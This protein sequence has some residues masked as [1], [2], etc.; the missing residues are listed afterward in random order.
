M[1][2]C[3]IAEYFDVSRPTINDWQRRGAPITNKGGDPALVAGWRARRDLAQAGAGNDPAFHDFP[4]LLENLAQR[5]L[6]LKRRIRMANEMPKDAQGEPGLIKA[7]ICA[8]L[9]LERKLLNLPATIIS[10]P[11]PETL[12]TRLIRAVLNALDES[13]GGTPA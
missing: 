7:A 3:Q 11:T 1:N 6:D 10:D 9:D 5:Q 4:D 13:K 12:P 8:R 2:K